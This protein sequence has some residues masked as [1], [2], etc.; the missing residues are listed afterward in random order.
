MTSTTNPPSSDPPASTPPAS[1]PPASNPPASD[2]P[3]STPP[4]STPPASTPP[5]STPP[6][7]TP[8]ASTEEQPPVEVPPAPIKEYSSD[9][10]FN[11]SNMSLFLLFLAVY[12]VT[13]FILGFYFRG[14]GETESF[15]SRFSRII[16]IILTLFVIG[17]IIYFYFSIEDSK[18]DEYLEDR[19]LEIKR[20]IEDEYSILIQ[21][22]FIFI[23]YLV[24]YVLRIPMRLGQ[25]PGLI[26]ITESIAWLLLFVIIVVKF[27]D[28]VFGVNILDDFSSLFNI[29]I[30]R[31]QPEP[32]PTPVPVDKREVFNVGNNKYNYQEAQA[33]CK[34]YGAELATYDQIEDAY[35]KGAEWCNYGWSAN[36][37]AFFP[38]QKQTWQ[39]LQSSERHKNNCGRPGVNGG[40]MGNPNLKFGVNCFGTKPVASDNDKSRLSNAGPTIPLSAEDKKMQEDI[41]YWMENKDKYLNINSFNYNKW[42]K[43]E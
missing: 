43:H 5:A 11:S 29:N 24:I 3:A 40:Y 32:E 34:A 18:K 41:D 2:P 20:Y 39:K 36:Q 7:S 26:F 10:I 12:F 19:A 17:Y 38:T 13:Y 15:A 31:S 1:N 6:A 27:F 37:M 30:K 4:A 8:P 21:T 23:F 14:S 33:I 25:K 16:D 35:N 42:S 28:L 9:D 22:A